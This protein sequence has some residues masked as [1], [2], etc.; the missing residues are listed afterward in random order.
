MRLRVDH[1]STY[2]F[3]PPMRGVVQSLRL[4]PSL[5][6]NQ[7]AI[8]WSVAVEGATLGAGFRDGAG[9]WVET[10]M[11]LGPVDSVTVRVA[12]EVETVDLGGVLRGHRERIRPEAYLRPTRA[13]KAD[14]AILELTG[15]ALGKLA[16][17][18]V[19][20]R[21]HALS[22]AVEE[23][24]AYRPEETVAG[25]TAAEALALGRGVCQDHA[26][27][28]IAAALAAGIPARYVTGYLFSG[29]EAE[30]P[31]EASHAWAELFIPDLGWVG[32]DASNGTC[33]DE[34]Y[35]RI[36]SG[37]D[38]VEAAPIRGVARG[39]GEEDLAVTVTVAQ[40]EGQSQTQQ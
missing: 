35:I 14:R 18:A 26:H 40:A 30:R 39:A 34:R 31:P 28:M 38:A 15:A 10:A 16:P 33:P 3:D 7:Q 8:D 13:T 37:G 27:L 22:R 5:C 32:F 36:G 9:D 4:T 6:E 29:E 1:A 20:D 21:A 17:E 19:L 24:V 2:R 12:G 25:T 11:L 23:A